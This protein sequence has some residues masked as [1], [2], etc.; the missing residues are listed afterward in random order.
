MLK[1]SDFGSQ[2]NYFAKAFKAYSKDI[3]E[4]KCFDT[5]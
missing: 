4:K 5:L 1:I 2:N 3:K